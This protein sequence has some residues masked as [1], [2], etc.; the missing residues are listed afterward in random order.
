[1]ILV[2][3]RLIATTTLNEMRKDYILDRW[4]VIAAQRKL[5]PTDFVKAREAAKPSV[6]PFCPG[7]EDM[8]PPADLVYLNNE[9]VVKDRD[10]DDSR[11]KNWLIRCFPN[12]YP[13]FMPSD[14]KVKINGGEN[15]ESMEAV[16]HHEVL[17]ESPNHSEHPG[18]AKVSQLV[19]VIGA[20]QDL[21]KLFLSKEYVKYVSIF[22]NHG[23]EA[24]A[25]LSHAHSQIIATP[26]IPQIIRRELEESID[27]WNKHGK[28]LF[29]EV[30][31][32]EK[33]GPRLV[34]EN[35]SFVA[36]APWA[37][38]H[39]FEF[40]LFPKR[41]QSTI[42]DM[43]SDEVRSLAMAFRVCFGGLRRLM[44]DPPYNFGFHM[45]S[46]QFYHWHL[47]VYPNITSWAGFEKST[48]MFINVISPEEAS[49]SLREAVKQEE[50]ELP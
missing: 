45:I 9:D 1:M 15:F 41:H 3:L 35:N 8:T 4:V 19:Y 12:R 48:G 38:V 2:N 14:K 46:N 24:G 42:L 5:R 31:E 36:F 39:P 22:R 6:C 21:F 29:C 43:T 18:V 37:S 47:E 40:W 16:G 26:I 28:C 7:N 13:A 44:N 30:V 49:S 34:W 33:T 11:H 32:K 50:K 25:S 20:Y 17:V 27:H 23:A 10:S